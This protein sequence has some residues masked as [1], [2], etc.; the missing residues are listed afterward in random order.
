[1][2]LSLLFLEGAQPLAAAGGLHSFA[3]LPDAEQ[4]RSGM[5]VTP[6]ILFDDELKRIT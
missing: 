4:T 1:M 5:R 3:T 6:L 2:S